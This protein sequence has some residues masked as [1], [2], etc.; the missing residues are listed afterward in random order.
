MA[1]EKRMNR[2]GQE[3]ISIGTLLIIVLGVVV[4]VVLILG[5]TGNLN[6]I[7]EKINLLP[8]QSLETVAQGCNIAAKTGLKVD[9]CDTFK[10]IK[11]DGKTEYINC[12][13]N[14]VQRG[15]DE[16]AKSKTAAWTDTAAACSLN[17]GKKPEQVQ[18]TKLINELSGEKGKKDCAKLAKVN[19]QLCSD[20]EKNCD[21]TKLPK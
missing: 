18:C 10:K 4:V 1:V 9:Y 21:P 3:G 2:K 16:D 19:G 11:I 17:A 5:V 13:D 12:E 7:F 14:R 8:G 20:A 15:L 6:F